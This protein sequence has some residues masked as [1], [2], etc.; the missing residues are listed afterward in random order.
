[1]SYLVVLIVDDPE[2]CPTVLDAWQE[3][4][5]SGATILPSTGLG[6]LVKGGL[7]DDMPLIPSL[8]DFLEVREEPHRTILSVVEEQSIVDQMVAAAQ[9]VIGDLDEPHTGFLFVVPVIQALG[10]GRGRK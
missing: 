10:L 1:M 2:D 8:E 9:D 6:R 4:G 3:I 5:V 7:R